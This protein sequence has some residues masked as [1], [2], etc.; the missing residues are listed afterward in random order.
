MRYDCNQFAETLNNDQ[1][2]VSDE[3]AFIAHIE[4]CSKCAA[5]VT[6]DREL[7]NELHSML[8]EPSP[9]TVLRGVAHSLQMDSIEM[10]RLRRN[11]R[12]LVLASAISVAATVII[13]IAKLK[14]SVSY[15]PEL[16]S[17]LSKGISILESV[18]FPEI[19]L[20][21]IIYKLAGS[22][23]LMVSLIGLIVLIWTFSILGIRESA[24]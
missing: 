24:K 3:K 7:E 11:F 2:E 16:D 21:G 1:L 4:H 19:D 23:L 6:L 15:I 17:A 13:I 20:A 22:P 9:D 10:S 5:L 14:S 18:H 12:L 8:P